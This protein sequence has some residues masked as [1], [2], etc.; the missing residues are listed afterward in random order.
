LRAAVNE[1]ETAWQAL[2]PG[3]L[4]Y[5][6]KPFDKIELKYKAAEVPAR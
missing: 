6:V 5:D 2:E 4:K 3:V 1:G